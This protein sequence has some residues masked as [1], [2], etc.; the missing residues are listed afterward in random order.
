LDASTPNPYA[1]PQSEA[2]R[3]PSAFYRVDN[4]RLS[5]AEYRRLSSDWFTLGFVLLLKALRVPV[6]SFFR[7]GLP[8]LE[9][10]T[11]FDLGAIPPRHSEA[12]REAT[13]AC[14]AAGLR[15]RLCYAIPV[16]GINKDAAAAVF[17]SEDGLVRATALFG[18]VRLGAVERVLTPFVVTSRLADGRRASS[19]NQLPFWDQPPSYITREFRGQ[20]PAAVLVSHRDWVASQGW[21]LEPWEPASLERE[22]LEKER[23]FLDF[24]IARGAV[25]PM[26]EGEVER[27]VRETGGPE[28]DAV[29]VAAPR[30]RPLRRVENALWVLL[31]LGLALGLANPVRPGERFRLN[32]LITALI[33]LALLG[34]AL[35]WLIR[36]IVRLDRRHRESRGDL[37]GPGG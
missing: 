8:R 4:R 14:E 19:W 22:C 32:V 37:D 20:A 1:A 36:G 15:L 12:W 3:A 6:R 33:G 30:P 26:T 27:L 7:F 28:G 23:E 16:L 9:R 11:T 35:V 17:L 34:L 24:L 13:A 31:A 18:R 25:V 10:L 21:A 5:Y 2:S 29:P